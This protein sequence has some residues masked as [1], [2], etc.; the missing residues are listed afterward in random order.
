ME[1]QTSLDAGKECNVYRDG[2][3]GGGGLEGV[4]GGGEGGRTES[5]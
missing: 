4:A 2:R 5:C 1:R 3:G